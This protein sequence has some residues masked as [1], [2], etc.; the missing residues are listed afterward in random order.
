MDAYAN[1]LPA[2]LSGGRR[3][4]VDCNSGSGLFLFMSPIR[5]EVMA[6]A[7]LVVVVNTGKIEQARSPRTVFN[8]PKTEFVAR[9]IGAHNVI[10]TDRGP[11]A[12]RADRL[13]LQ[14]KKATPPHLQA[15]V[16]A[17]E[18]QGTH[19]HAALDSAASRN[20]RRP[21]NDTPPLTTSWPAIMRN[22]DVL[23]QPEGPSRQQLAPAP[24]FKSMA[25][26]AV[27]LPYCLVTWINSSAAINLSAFY[28][29]KCP[30]EHIQS[31][32]SFVI[33]GWWPD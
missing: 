26:A 7:D 13:A 22:V 19:V 23:P 15:I 5:D 16:R 29:S 20:I 24:I 17:V 25:S 11:I 12:I 28:D 6:L 30:S 1:R 14:T 4:C 18:Y 3:N 33:Q 31:Y 10:M 9:F 27:V 21:D 8:A 32:E 2:Q